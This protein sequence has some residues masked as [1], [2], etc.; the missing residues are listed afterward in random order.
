MYWREGNQYLLHTVIEKKQTI[1]YKVKSFVKIWHVLCISK[2]QVL[3]P[4]EKKE[5]WIISEKKN[6]KFCLS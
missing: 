2:F 3:F 1:I 6:R 5:M 4:S